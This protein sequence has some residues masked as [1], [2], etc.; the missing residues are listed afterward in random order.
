MKE[1][2]HFF[3]ICIVCA[4]YE[5]AKA[6]LDE[7]AVRC[8]VS[9]VQAF[10][11]TDRRYEYR[12]TAIYNTKG[13]LLTVLVMWLTD[14]GPQGTSLDLGPVLQEFHPRLA[15]MTGIC[16]GWKEKVNLGD[17]V[18]AE[19]A[20]QYEEGKIV[21]GPDGQPKTLPEM[22][23]YGATARVIQYVKGFEAWKKPVAEVKRGRFER[24]LTDSEHPQCY[25]ATM[26]S[27][28]AVRGDNPFPWLTE[29]RNR[30]TIALDM[31]AAAFYFTLRSF[32]DIRAL[33][34]KGVC[35]FADTTKDDTYHN[36]AAHASAI[37]LLSFIQEYVTEET[38]PTSR[39]QQRSPSCL[40]SNDKGDVRLKWAKRLVTLEDP[41]TVPVIIS[42][43]KVEPEPYIRYWLAYAL[44]QISCELALDSQGWNMLLR[45]LQ[46][47]K[48]REVDSF[49]RKG[50]DDALR[51]IQNCGQYTTAER[52]RR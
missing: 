19:Y 30:K 5:E 28:M 1:Q 43:L 4:L 42:R 11:R 33:V 29:N 41:C 17:L 14:S 50:I 8:G 21:V 25:I 24:E 44:G 2:A 27:G 15:A 46:D 51:L 40:L 38:M 3:D 36:Y 18:V 12:C 20:Y 37:Y 39:A 6:V 7:I 34:V 10:S 13:E 9:F 23:T 49:A 45:A 47:A 31:E 52:G 26:A 35:D 48:E 16:A 32:P 22:K